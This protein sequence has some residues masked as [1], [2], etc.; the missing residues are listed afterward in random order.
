[1]HWSLAVIRSIVR[2]SFEVLC[3]IM[4]VNCLLNRSALSVFVTAV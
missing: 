2:F 1:M 4:L 3:V